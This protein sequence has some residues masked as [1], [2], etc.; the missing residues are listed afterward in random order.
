MTEET[1]ECQ[2]CHQI[3]P[4]DS[5]YKRKDRNGEHTWTMSYCGPCDTSHVTKSRAKHIDK[6]RK[7]QKEY[8]NNY[9]YNHTD[10]VKIIQK[11]YYYN[12]LPPEKQAKYKRKVEKNWP[13]WIEQICRN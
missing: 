7:Y 12:K 10:K 8:S 4:K 9:Y 2:L 5:F 13:E 1:K 6:Y 3:F 11:R